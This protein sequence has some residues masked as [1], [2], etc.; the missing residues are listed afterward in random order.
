ML[1]PFDFMDLDRISLEGIDISSTALNDLDEGT[2]T[3]ILAN[4]WT[5][6]ESQSSS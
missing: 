3:S 5:A 4:G 6:G 1:S 2:K